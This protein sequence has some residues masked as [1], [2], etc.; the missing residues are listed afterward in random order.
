MMVPVDKKGRQ[1]SRRGINKKQSDWS[2]E[3]EAGS[4]L[5]FS[6]FAVLLCV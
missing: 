5:S 3:R 4:R 1:I 2:L 6:F